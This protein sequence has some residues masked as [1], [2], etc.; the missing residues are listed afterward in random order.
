[1]IAGAEIIVFG[2]V[3]LEGSGEELVDGDGAEA[4]G[5]QLTDVEDGEVEDVEDD[6]REEEVLGGICEDSHGGRGAQGYR[7]AFDGWGLVAGDGRG[8]WV[9]AEEGMQIPRSLSPRFARL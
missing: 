2:F 1:L 7:K 6:E 8:V 5:A 4:G 3:A 9:D